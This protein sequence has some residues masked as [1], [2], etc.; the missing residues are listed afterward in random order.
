MKVQSTNSES[1][2]TLIEM[3]V[4]VFITMLLA[5]VSIPLVQGTLQSYRL[6]SAATAASSAIQNVRFQCVMLGYPFQISFDP[7]SLSYQVLSMA[8]NANAFTDVGGPVPIATGGN[9]SLSPPTVLQF[10]PGGTVQAVTGSLSFTL[11]NGTMTKT[12]SVSGVG[13]VT[14][15]P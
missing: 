14:I 9:I 1:G 13:N 5:A 12:I 8:P 3:L 10:S 4:V 7:A 6:N 11:T 2:F 15:S